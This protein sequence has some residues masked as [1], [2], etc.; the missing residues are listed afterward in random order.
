MTRLALF[1]QKLGQYILRPFLTE[2]WS[3]NIFKLFLLKN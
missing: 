3:I 2:K 1:D